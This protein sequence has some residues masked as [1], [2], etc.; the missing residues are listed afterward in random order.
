MCFYGSFSSVNYVL[1]RVM[2]HNGQPAHS[3]DAMYLKA[4]QEQTI[5]DRDNLTDTFT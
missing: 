4:F 1:M 5:P 2:F 3:K